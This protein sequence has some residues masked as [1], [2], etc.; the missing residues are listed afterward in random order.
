MKT[1]NYFKFPVAVLR[2]A[3]VDVRTVCDN[4]MDYAIYVKYSDCEDI[5]EVESFFDITISDFKSSLKNGETLFTKYGTNCPMVSVSKDILFDFYGNHATKTEFEIAIFL[6]YCGLKSILGT[7]TYTKTNNGL[8]LAR[9]A[10]Y[11]TKQEF[12]SACG[13]GKEPQ[14]YFYKY[15][16]DDNQIRYQLTQKI[17]EKELVLDW[18]LKYYSRGVRGFYFSFTMK[19]ERL[20]LEVEKRKK[21]N[22]LKLHNQQKNE[23]IRAAKKQLNL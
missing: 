5:K 1:K 18:H 4:G 9:M 11:G 13:T 20:V 16:F 2:G 19:Y 22:R 12:D 3:F 15:F 23:A 7:K 14:P 17:I 21:S 8:L 6:A 10:G